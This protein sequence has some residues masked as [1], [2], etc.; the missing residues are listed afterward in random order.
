[1]S[2]GEKNRVA[3]QVHHPEVARRLAEVPEEE[4]RVQV[5]PTSSG[6]PTAKSRGLSIHSRHDPRAEAERQVA[7]DVDEKTSAVVVLGFGLG[8]AAEEVWRRFPELPILVL[9]PDA[10]L[11]A[12]ALQS[13]DLTGLLSDER[14]FFLV[15]SKPEEVSALLP[16]LP[17]ARPAFLRLRPAIESY[18]GW[19]RVAEEVVQSWL[20]RREI[21]LNTLNRFG[22]LWVRNLVRNMRS[23][24]RAPGISRL[25]G[26]CTGLP[27]LVIAG[28]PSLDHVV[29]YLSSLRERLVI[30]SVNTPLARC[31]EAGVQPDFAVVVDPQYWASRFMDWTQPHSRAG[32]AEEA[33]RIIVAEP[34][35]HPRLLRSSV[36]ASRGQATLYLCSS[37]FPLGETL[38]AAVGQ[39]GKLGA[40]GS[41][42][43]AAWDLAR[44]LGA[45]P[46]YTAGLDL[47]YPGMRTHCKGV[48]TEE[49]WLSACGRLRPLE[50]S[51]FGYLREIGLFLVPSAAGGSTPTDRRMLLY[52]WWFENQLTMHPEART[53]TLSPDSV[54]I[55][56]MPLTR[57]SEVLSFPPVRQEIDARIA[58]ER[59]EAAEEMSARRD[60]PV[61]RQALEDLLG[62]LGE[63]EALSARALEANQVLGSVL[64]DRE[65]AAE[66]LSEL[67][68]IDRRILAVSQRSIAGFLMQ[69]DIHRIGSRGEGKVSKNETL[70]DGAALYRGIRESALWQKEIIRK[71]LT[72]L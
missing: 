70:S 67:D 39:K 8:Y 41:V 59:R 10:S 46:I 49:L 2:F 57:L 9:E 22:R 3:L 25:Q 55:Q 42:A 34:S 16:A 37:L 27:S 19:F 53:F 13:R 20:L 33:A 17:L 58:R 26:L 61:L 18:P 64:P 5:I 50:A 35:T 1:M 71:A 48:F 7:R 44:H 65:A 6:T 66:L 21:N 12:A 11:F 45:S 14:V 60:E 52:K 4:G 15:A 40:G 31:A 23:F 56:G 30:I 68:G 43:T 28:G 62:G 47:G 38:E 32:E 54:A 72:E 24:L 36:P 51:S 69:S 29:P 63:L